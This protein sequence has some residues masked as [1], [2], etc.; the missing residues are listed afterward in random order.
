MHTVSLF[1]SLF[2]Y[3]ILAI[4][5]LR[6]T[7]GLIFIW[8]WYEKM[9][10]E[11]AAR[12]RFFEELGLTPAM[13][14]FTLVT[15]AEGIAGVFLIVGLWTQ[16]AA[17]VTGILMALATLIKWRNPSALQKNTIEFYIILAI[18]SFALLFLGPGVFAVDL[19]L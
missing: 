12:V 19:P 5:T 10:R 7:L 8:F 1:P 15:Y 2:D 16:G 18:V 17:M 3:G 9:F 4:F 14:Y 11:R 6:V 13:L